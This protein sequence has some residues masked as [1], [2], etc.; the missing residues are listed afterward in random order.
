MNRLS[1]RRHRMDSPILIRSLSDGKLGDVLDWFLRLDKELREV[2]AETDKE[3][4][5]VLEGMVLPPFSPF[6]PMLNLFFFLS[7]FS[8]TKESWHYQ[9]YAKK[10]FRRAR[11]FVR[12]SL[13]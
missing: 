2:K 8:V 1:D 6:Q 4:K 10:L 13:P 5:L 7:F 12:N 11:R 9:V 3:A